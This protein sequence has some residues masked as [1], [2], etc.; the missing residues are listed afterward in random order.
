[1]FTI[2]YHPMCI[3]PPDLRRFVVNARYVL[4]DPWEWDYDSCG[5]DPERLWHRALDFGNSVANIGH[6]CNNC[7]LFMHCGGWNK[8]YINAFNGAG[9]SS[10]VAAAETQ[11]PGYM[12]DQNPANHEK[13][14]F[15]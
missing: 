13:G 4:Y 6:P 1:M 7:G 5:L 10:C 12:H 14:Y 2:R 15:G 9:L 8:T 3:L 11:V